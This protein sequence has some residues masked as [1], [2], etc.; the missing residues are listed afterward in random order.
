[1]RIVAHV[2]LAF[3][4]VLVLG[5]LWRLGPIDRAVPDLVGLSAIYLGLTAR[6]RVA[7]AV[8]GAVV[9]GYLADLLI[10]S[11]RGLLA[12]AAGVLCL[13]GHL[14]QGRLYVRGR[15]F[16]L[17][18]SLL[19]GVVASLVVLTLRALVGLPGAPF[20]DQLGG[21]LGAALLSGVAGPPFFALA[22]RVDA[23]FART[24]RERD[25]ALE[26]LAP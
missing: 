18:V 13:L 4:L 19:V 24:Q 8:A 22:R 6:E 16:V 12:T 9:I 23:R 25:A 21:L 15:P 17:V 1:V 10:G 11:P 7:P 14:V 5:A 2:F 20:G 26:G 3:G